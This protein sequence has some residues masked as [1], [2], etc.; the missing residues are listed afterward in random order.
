ME[1]LLGGPSE[2]WLVDDPECDFSDD[3]L[4]NQPPLICYFKRHG[5]GQCLP[6][7]TPSDEEPEHFAPPGYAL[8]TE[9]FQAPAAAPVDAL[10]P[11]L[12]TNLQTEMEGNEAVATARTRALVPDLNLLEAEDMEEGNED[13]PPAPSL[14]LPTPSP[15]ARVL[16]RRFAS[17]MAARPA[18][19]RRGT[20]SPEALG[21]TNG[22]AE[23]RL[24]EAA[25]HLPS[26]SMEE[27]GRR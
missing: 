6:S 24:N 2:G 8:V 27:P 15:E 13:A 14:A 26:S 9:V 7:P 23:L 16:L 5:N 25:P 19:I 3:E 4:E 12:T 18:G 10:P 17:V 21:L 20:W 11:A 1:W 22:V